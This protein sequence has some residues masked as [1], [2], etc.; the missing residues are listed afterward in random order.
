ML[1]KGESVLKLLGLYVDDMNYKGTGIPDNGEVSMRYSREISE[2]HDGT[3]EVRLGVEGKY[4]NGA[5]FNV[6]MIGIFIIDSPEPINDIVA[7]TLYKDNTVAI[8][9]PYI[10][11]QLSLLTTQ[12]GITPITIQ[13]MNIVRMF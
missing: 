9:F 7:A 3:H 11:T 5:T 1:N 12:P 8:M 4:S 6:Y 2:N 10:R 13:P